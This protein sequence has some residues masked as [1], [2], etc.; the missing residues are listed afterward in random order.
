MGILGVM[1]ELGPVAAGRA[2]LEVGR[3]E[4]ARAAFAAALAEEETAEALDGMG[5][6]G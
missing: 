6:S 3:W 4:E 1:T 5:A 2:A